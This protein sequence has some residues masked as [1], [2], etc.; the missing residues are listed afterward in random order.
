MSTSVAEPATSVTT[1]DA[2]AQPALPPVVLAGWRGFVLFA[3]AA[4]IITNGI[5]GLTARWGLGPIFDFA[6]MA[7][8]SFLFV[9]L[10]DGLATLLWK[11]FGRLLPAIRLSRLND[12]IQAVPAYLVGRT[13]GIVLMVLGN[14]LWPDSFLKY[15]TLLLPGKLIVTVSGAMGA[16]IFIARIQRQPKVRYALI[17]AAVALGAGFAFWLLYPGTDGYLVRAEPVAVTPLEFA[18][19]ALTGP[20][21]VRSMSYGSGA[22]KRR[23][24][25]GEAVS[26]ATPSVDGS[27]IFN[28]YSGLAQGYYEWYNGFDFTRLPLNALVWYPEGEGPFPLVLIVHGNHAMTEPSD[29]GYSYLGEHLAG[30]GFIA[31]SV[32]ENFLNGFAVADGDMQEIPLRAWILLKHLEQWRSWNETPGNPFYGRVDLDRVALIGHSR[33]GEAVAHAA[34]LNQKPYDPVA[35]VS[36]A[37][38]FGFGIRSVVAIAPADNRYRPGG[39]PIHIDNADYLLLAGAHDQDMFYLDGLGQFTRARFDDNPDGF[40]AIAYLYRGNHGNFNTVWGD[41]D[42]GVFESVLLNRKPLLSA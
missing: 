5:F 25:Y 32:D 41:D 19:P 21:S 27:A 26:L 24:E 16:L 28:G 22:D 11:L 42:Q 13:V 17:G 37:E 10:F 7:L 12:I 2:Q 18:N 14:V 9:Y 23:T 36:S 35:D 29:P 30:H 33:G 3:W 15:T 34:V 8:L 1:A 31:A 6:L 4:L 38:D 40:K 20:Y 39:R